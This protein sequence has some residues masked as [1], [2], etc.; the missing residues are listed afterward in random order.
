MPPKKK[1]IRSIYTDHHYDKE[2]LRSFMLPLYI[3]KIHSVRF[4]DTGEE[5]KLTSNAKLVYGYLTGLGYNYGYNSIYP[6]L[7]D[8]A[9]CMAL[10][11][12][13][14][15]NALKVLEAAKLVK[16][17]KIKQ[18][19]KFDSSHY[20]IY[21]PN[22]IDRVEWLNVDGDIMLGKHYSF[23]TKQFRQSKSDIKQA[24]K[25]LAGL[26]INIEKEVDNEQ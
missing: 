15:R 11:E 4:K 18:Q 2:D 20:W 8:I 16:I 22:M 12:K 25:L 23:N 9:D 19:G 13:T 21:R 5:I 6:N 17:V 14:I 1:P 10:N 3:T 26:L 24:D 7:T